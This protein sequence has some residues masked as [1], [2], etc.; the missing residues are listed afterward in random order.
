MRW[1]GQS[2]LWGVLA[3]LTG[4]GLAL[5]FAI[6]GQFGEGFATIAKAL[7]LPLILWGAP[8]LWPHP[9]VAIALMTGYYVGL[10]VTGRYVVA[11]VRQSTLMPRLAPSKPPRPQGRGAS[12]G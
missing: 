2:L 9:V 8:G 6:L 12:T 1:F 7:V 11:V 4:T 10:I 3:G 5:P